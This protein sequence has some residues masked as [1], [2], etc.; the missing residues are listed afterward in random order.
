MAPT[1]MLTVAGLISLSLSFLLLAALRISTNPLPED[2]GYEVMAW[3]RD[4]A[5][6][7]GSGFIVAAVA[8]RGTGNW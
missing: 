6:Y 8:L 1:R 5:A 4:I 3:L 2:F 7:V